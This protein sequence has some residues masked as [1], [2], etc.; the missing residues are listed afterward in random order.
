MWTC[1]PPTP[2]LA[3]LESPEAAQEN[4][5]RTWRGN[6]NV[7]DLEL[8]AKKILIGLGITAVPALILLG[9]LWATQ[10]ALTTHS[11]KA[12]SAARKGRR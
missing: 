8:L 1:R 3:N 5:E 4:P 12:A 11:T 9:G 10:H 6:M 2:V 7:R